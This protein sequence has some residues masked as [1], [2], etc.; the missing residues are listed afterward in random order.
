MSIPDLPDMYA[1]GPQAQ[2]LRAYILG[3]S[4]ML[5]LQ[6]LLLLFSEIHFSVIATYFSFN[7]HTENGKMCT[8]DLPDMR[9]GVQQTQGLRT[10]IS[11]KSLMPMLHL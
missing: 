1:Q 11:D 6:L 8:R 5:M 9:A 4:L 3:K 10:Y 2:E 7:P